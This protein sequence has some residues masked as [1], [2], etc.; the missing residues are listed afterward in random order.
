[1][2]LDE[3]GLA[4]GQY[5]R[6]KVRI[7]TTLPLMR[8]ITFDDEDEEEPDKMKETMVREEKK[9]AEGESDFL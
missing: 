8:G 5:M 2:D 6:I 9:G 3:N 4:I 1:M 7:D